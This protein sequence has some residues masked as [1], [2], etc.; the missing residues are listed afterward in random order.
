MMRRQLMENKQLI[1]KTYTLTP[2]NKNRLMVSFALKDNLGF[3]AH[4]KAVIEKI[5]DGKIIIT[6]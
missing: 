5:K 4:Q 1:S 3:E 2:H 6:E